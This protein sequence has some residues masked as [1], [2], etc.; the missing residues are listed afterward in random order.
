M[1]LTPSDARA[2]L[3][4]LRPLLDD[5]TDRDVFVLPSFAAIWVAR[6]ELQGSPVAW[7]AQDVHPEDQGAHTGDVSA[8]MLADLGCRYVE[9]GHAERERDHGET[10]DLVARKVAAVVRWGM[11]PIVCVGE[12]ARD[13]DDAALAEVVGRLER[14]LGRTPPAAVGDL[15]IAYEPV[16]AIGDG[17]R[18]APAAVVGTML[19]A[20]GDWLGAAGYDRDR[21]R[22]IY[23]GSIDVEVAGAILGQ[24]GVDGLFVGRSGLDPAV[25][26]RIARTPL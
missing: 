16:W 7:G 20:I 3:G 13:R 4:R 26:A 24:P 6:E 2:Y 15:V 14:A 10:P 23:G 22:V 12:R 9:V 21:A 8:P 19:R 25:F 18:P 5:V 11:V 1:H 17:A